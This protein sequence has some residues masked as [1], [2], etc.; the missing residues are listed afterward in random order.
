MLNWQL[1]PSLEQFIKSTHLYDVINKIEAFQE[2]CAEV[3]ALFKANLA[4]HLA[5]LQPQIKSNTSRAFLGFYD[6]A[7]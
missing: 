2:L 1:T 6:Y 4:Q 3:P 5:S 7:F